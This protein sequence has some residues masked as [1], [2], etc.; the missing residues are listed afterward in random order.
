M[1]TKEID[2]NGYSIPIYT[3]NYA[4]R[5]IDDRCL[6]VSISRTVPSWFNKPYLTLKNVQPTSD[7]LTNWNNSN[8]TTTDKIQYITNYYYSTIKHNNVDTFEDYL[9]GVIKL[10]INKSNSIIQP[11]KIVLLCYE[12]PE[13]FCHRL[14]L[15]TYLDMVMGYK[16]LELGHDN[17][18]QCEDAKIIRIV[19]TKLEQ[20]MKGEQ[21]K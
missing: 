15:T 13:T 11:E 10:A 9:K 5:L 17:V 6:C 12:A 4:S 1:E 3:S 18:F 8:K 14:I 20:Y 2:I 21:T 19:L 7:V 16:I